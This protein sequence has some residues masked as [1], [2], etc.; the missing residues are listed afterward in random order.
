MAEG[1]PHW[2][3]GGFY[4]LF[5]CT[6]ALVFADRI[7]DAKEAGERAVVEL[8]VRNMRVGLQLAVAE[9]VMEGR[10]RE[11]RGW[12]GTNPVRWL[13]TPPVGYVGECGQPGPQGLGDGEWC[14]DVPRRELIYRPRNTRHLAVAGAAEANGLLRWRVGLTPPDGLR[15]MLV[16]PYTWAQE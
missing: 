3:Q 4:F 7:L 10:E 9:A 8:T 16:S 2:L 6:L 12:A 14:F 1:F 13:A 11:T 15:V 5:F